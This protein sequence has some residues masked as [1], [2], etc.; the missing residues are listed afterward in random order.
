MLSVF[1][2]RM[3]MLSALCVEVK[4]IEHILCIWATPQ[5]AKQLWRADLMPMLKK[6]TTFPSPAK[7]THSA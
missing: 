6:V 3:F 5:N 2:R 1:V 7:E 4:N